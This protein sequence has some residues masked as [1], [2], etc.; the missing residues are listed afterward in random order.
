MSLKPHSECRCGGRRW[1][2]VHEHFQ[3]LN[4]SD[5][6]SSSLPQRSRSRRCRGRRW[7]TDEA[8]RWTRT[9]WFDQPATWTSGRRWLWPAL[10]RR[11]SPAHMKQTV[12]VSGTNI[13]KIYIIYMRVMR[14]DGV[15]DHLFYSLSFNDELVADFDA[16]VQEALQQVG[17]ADA[18][19]V[20]SLIHTWAHTHTQHTHSS[21]LKYPSIP[22]QVYFTWWW[23]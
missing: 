17:R 7:S 2:S 4:L 11:S 9:S 14:I 1:F 21:H 12:G 20:R 10:R 23:Q 18:H 13:R 3:I 8:E 15:T 22:E 19:Q 16:G 5:K 6:F